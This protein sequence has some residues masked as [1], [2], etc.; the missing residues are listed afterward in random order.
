MSPPSCAVLSEPLMTLMAYSR[1]SRTR[2]SFWLSSSSCSR[3][4][5][6]ERWASTSVCFLASDAAS[7][8]CTVSTLA[9][10]SCW[11]QNR[12]LAEVGLVD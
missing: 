9:F 2:R 5:S 6:R 3:R 1:A 10:N 11:V 7:S 4:C 12:N 8:A